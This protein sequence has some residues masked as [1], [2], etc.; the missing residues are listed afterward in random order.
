MSVRR[1]KRSRDMGKSLRHVVAVVDI[2][3]VECKVV[4]SNSSKG[5]SGLVF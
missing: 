4:G 3:Y 2:W 1:D 5:G